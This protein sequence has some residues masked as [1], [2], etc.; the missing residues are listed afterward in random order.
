MSKSTKA[1]RITLMTRDLDIFWSLYEARYLTIEAIEWLHFPQWRE[2][3]AQ[4]QAAQAAGATKPY[5]PTTQ[6]Y[7]R[8]RLLQGNNYVRRIVRPTM[9]AIDTYRR[10][11]D[12]FLLTEKGAT[13]LAEYRGLE[14]EQLHYG[15][16]RQRSYLMLQHHVAVGRVYAALRSRIESKPGI[17]FSEWRSEH[18]AAKD[19]DRVVMRVPQPDGSV[20]SEETGIQPDGAFFIDYEGGRTLFFVEV[21]RDQPLKK[22]K[23]KMWAYEAYHNSAVLQERYGCSAFVLLGMALDAAHQ[24]RLL[25]ATGEALALLYPNAA[26]RAAA[27]GRYLIGHMGH[28]HPT[29]IGAGWH[30]LRQVKVVERGGAVPV[31]V[32]VETAEYVLIT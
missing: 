10:E 19:F 2:R 1:Q 9:L 23:E 25:E 20:R 32:Q 12:L 27:Q 3:Y 18:H 29:L 11:P 21:E 24:R 5:I 7:T 26:Q 13:V 6:A 22:W 31:G 8:L 16:P 17:Q 4:W 30:E 14:L 15:E 28:A